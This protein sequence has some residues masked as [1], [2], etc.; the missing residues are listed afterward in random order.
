LTAELAQHFGRLYG[1][2]A[3][4]VIGDARSLDGLGR[5]FGP[6]L[7]EAEAR[8]LVRYEW[9]ETA[10]DILL[11]RTKHGLHMNDE[12]RHA[13]AEWLKSVPVPA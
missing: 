7:T 1:T 8:Y 10:D 4:D 11:R 5:R 6:L 3:K 12:E 9:A 2:L 13:F